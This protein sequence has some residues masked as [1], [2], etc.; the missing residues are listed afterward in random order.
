MSRRSKKKILQEWILEL[1]QKRQ[2]TMY[3]IGQIDEE[4]RDLRKALYK[5]IRRNQL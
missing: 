3:Q 2:L 1:R 4:L 5:E